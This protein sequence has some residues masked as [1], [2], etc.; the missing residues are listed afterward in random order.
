[1]LKQCFSSGTATNGHTQYEARPSQNWPKIT[2]YDHVPQIFVTSCTWLR[3][4]VLC[5]R[6]L[7]CIE[8]TERSI[9]HF[10]WPCLNGCMH[11]LKSQHG[12]VITS[13]MKCGMKF[14]PTLHW[15]CD[16]LSM[17]GLKLI[18]VGKRDPRCFQLQL[19]WHLLCVHLSILGKQFL[20]RTRPSICELSRTPDKVSIH[21]N[22]V[23]IFQFWG[24]FLCITRHASV[25]F[26][27]EICCVLWD[28]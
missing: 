21:R 6:G 28:S 7:R 5:D 8:N 18:H 1:M 25:V 20:S 24:S 13:I 19:S 3:R 10:S 27:S 4:G 23:Q 17:P 2:T 11:N 12:L 16:Y 9:Y 14:H 15:T 26:P 22:T